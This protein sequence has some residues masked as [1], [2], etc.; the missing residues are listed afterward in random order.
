MQKVQ[1]C[2]LQLVV[3]LFKTRT[4][5]NKK[6]SQVSV[7][8]HDEFVRVVQCNSIKCKRQN[9]KYSIVFQ[10]KS[11]LLQVILSKTQDLL[12]LREII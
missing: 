2:I 11:Y 7:I 8:F 12:L 1:G 5:K 10:G 9:H 4:F 3:Y 6:T